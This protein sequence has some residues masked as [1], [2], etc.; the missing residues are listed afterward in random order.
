MA[1]EFPLDDDG[2]PNLREIPEGDWRAVLRP[3]PHLSR[4]LALGRLGRSPTGDEWMM[5]AELELSD[6]LPMRVVTPTAPEGVAVGAEAP[7]RRRQVNVSLSAERHERLA[8]AA[9]GVGLKPAQL[10][11]L[12]ITRGVDQMLRS[13]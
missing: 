7:P 11:R 2:L 13:R 10:A 9:R 3:L 5:L 8:Q 4:R 12:L 6:P 1:T